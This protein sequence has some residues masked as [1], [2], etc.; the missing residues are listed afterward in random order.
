MK[1][2]SMK[3]KLKHVCNQREVIWAVRVSG[4]ILGTINTHLIMFHHDF[5]MEKPVL[6]F[7][8]F[9]TL[10]MTEYKVPYKEMGDMKR[11]A[12]IFGFLA[13]YFLVGLLVY[14]V[15]CPKLN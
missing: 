2:K 15:G 8:L 4:L 10:G 6:S 12:V 13:L 1:M 14:I 7:L 9:G 3:A 11:T 5:F